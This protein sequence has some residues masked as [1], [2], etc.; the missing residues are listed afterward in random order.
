MKKDK[1][2]KWCSCFTYIILV[3]VLHSTSIA[4]PA[5]SITAS[6]NTIRTGEPDTIQLKADWP[7]HALQKGFLVPDSFPHFEVWDK[8]SVIANENGFIQNIVI[9]GY[10]S[11]R[12]NLPPFE[13]AEVK[14]SK[15][16]SFAINVQPV[17]VDSLQDYHDIKDIIDVPPVP[18]WSFV[19]FIAGLTLVSIVALY[20]LL[21]KAGIGKRAAISK[22]VKAGAFQ[23]AMEALQKL[24]LQAKQPGPA[25]P[26]YTSITAIYRTY[27]QEAYQYRSL[28]QTGGELILQAKPLL[29]EADFYQLANAIRLSDAVKFA[30]YEPAQPDWITSFA[31]IRQSIEALETKLATGNG[32]PAGTTGN[33]QQANK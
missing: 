7:G 27:L 17:N 5:L 8:G 23:R 16:D 10:D 28:Q 20:F 18:Q 4:Q 1:K 6:K 26:F 30:K 2:F 15:T 13:L 22:G 25:K 29:N 31:A 12:F 24:E 33:K 9:T 3:C 32:Q 11:G 14:N 19:L 21:R